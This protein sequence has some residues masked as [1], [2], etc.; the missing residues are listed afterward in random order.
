MKVFDNRKVTNVLPE[1]TVIGSVYDVVGSHRFNP[2]L[3]INYCPTGAALF[4]N[5]STGSLTEFKPNTRLLLFPDAT[6]TA[7]KD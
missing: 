5:L 2:Y 4:V 1:D 6:L 3:R 7:T